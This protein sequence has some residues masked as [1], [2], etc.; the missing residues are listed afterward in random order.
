MIKCNVTLCGTI[1][2]DASVRTGKDG[3]EF[4]SFPLQVSIP[5]KNGNDGNME[6]SVSKD[7]GQDTVHEYRYGS[8]CQGHGHPFA[9]TQGREALFQPV[10]RFRGSFDAGN[11]DSVKGQ[12]V[13]RGKTGKHIEERKDKTGK[14]YLMSPRSARRRSMTGLSIN[15]CAFSVSARKRRSGC[16]R[17]SR[18]TRKEKCP[19]RCTT[20]SRTSHAVWKNS[21]SMCQR[22]AT[23]TDDGYGRLQTTERGRGRT[24]RK[25]LSTCSPR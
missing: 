22:P 9:E 11:T 5:G 20:A 17:V 8:P 7:G 10:G 3:K 21:T 14:P 13:F 15:G 18:W 6:V 4:V 25:R 12:M 24:A 1:S 16:S 23:I 2:R 19:S